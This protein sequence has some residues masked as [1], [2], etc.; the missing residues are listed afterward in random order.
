MIQVVNRALDIL[1]FIA[2]DK[3][4]IYSLTEIADALELNHATCA[5][6][7]KTMVN[8]NFIDQ[9][10]HKKGYRL[11][12]MV[13]QIAG[14]TYYEQELLKAASHEMELLTAAINETCLLGV[15]KKDIRVA[16]HQVIANNELN[17]KSS[18][19]KSAYN[20]ASGR[21]LVASLSN[22][23]LQEY[24]EKYGIPSADFWKEG[25]TLAGF[26]KEVQKIKEQGY[27]TQTTKSH[28]VGIAVPIYKQ[29]TVVASL[30]IYLPESRFIEMT[31][32]NILATLNKAA[33]SISKRL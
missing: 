30:S 29:N 23:L 6:I 21:V 16:I 18:L 5:N 27:A 32:S 26:K 4:K 3:N 20:S 13:F 8:R 17:V 33:N 9:I 19:E 2:K 10:G 28:I 7:I 15:L 12:F 24:V 1:E 31:R 14:N 22:T 11:G 25:A